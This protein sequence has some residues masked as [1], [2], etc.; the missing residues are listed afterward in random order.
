[1]FKHILLPVDTD[2]PHQARSRAEAIRVRAA[3]G[4]DE[5]APISHSKM[6]EAAL[7]KAGASVETLYYPNE[8]HGFYLEANRA[9]YARRLLAFLSRHLGGGVATAPTEGAKGKAP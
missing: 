4:E 5:V 9:E 3:G 7:V 2:A 8:G 6:M 1:M